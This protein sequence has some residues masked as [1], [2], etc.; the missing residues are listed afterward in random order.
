M[1]SISAAALNL[2][3]QSGE[4]ICLLDIRE[5]YEREICCI[6]NAVFIPME[7]AA[8]DPS[9]IQPEIETVVYCHHGIRSYLLIKYLEEKFG[10]RNLV[11]L[12]GGINEWALQIDPSMPRY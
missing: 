6:P 9:G 11:N 10:F 4:N 5:N 3:L 7:L 12:E 2:K 8:K 1:K